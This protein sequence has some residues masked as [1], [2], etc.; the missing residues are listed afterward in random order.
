MPMIR[1]KLG[2]LWI[3]LEVNSSSVVIHSTLKHSCN[4]FIKDPER[5]SLYDTDNPVNPNVQLLP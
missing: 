3:S 4:E 5:N 2:K 1:G